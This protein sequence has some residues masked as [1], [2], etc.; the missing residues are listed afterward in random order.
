MLELKVGILFDW[1][2][3]LLIRWFVQKGEPSHHPTK[4]IYPQKR[5]ILKRRQPLHLKTG[6]TMQP[7]TTYPTLV[8]HRFDVRMKF[9]YPMDKID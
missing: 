6:L 1:F 4:L 9:H 5:P 7:I 2:I 3:K 8:L